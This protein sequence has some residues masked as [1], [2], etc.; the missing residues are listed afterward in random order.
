MENA[1]K[2]LMMSA[3]ILVAVMIVSLAARLF[4]AARGVVGSYDSTMQT[5]ATT[6]FNSRFTKYVGPGNNGEGV[7][8]SHK[9][10]EATIYDIISL[11]NFAYEYNSRMVLDPKHTDQ[12]R[13]PAIVEIY[14]QNSSGENV[15]K[16]LQNHSEIYNDLMKRCYYDSETNPNA[17]NIITFKVTEIRNNAVGRI[18]Y[19]TFQANNDINNR[20]NEIWN[21]DIRDKTI[22]N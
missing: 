19:I 22:D 16:N 9:R 4:R 17:K 14:I 5:V 1:S 10:E 18:N 7:D 20:L 13:E 12:D 3:T 8:D 21:S 11:A 6:Q 2:L 15:I